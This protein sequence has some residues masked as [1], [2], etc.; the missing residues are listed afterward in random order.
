M[1]NIHAP[2]EPRRRAG[3][4]ARASLIRGA[5]CALLALA[6]P[7]WAA[8]QVDAANG[9]VTDDVTGLVW[10]RATF[11]G[12]ACANG[13]NPS[14]QTYAWQ[15]ALQTAV[16][17]N[18]CSHKGHSDWR[19]PNIQ[20][21]ASLVQRD[22]SNPAIDVDAFADA[23]VGRYWS[24]TSQSPTHAWNVGFFDGTVDTAPTSD[25]SAYR[26]RVRLVRGGQPFAGADL[27]GLPPG[28]PANVQAVAGPGQVVLS[29]GPPADGG[30]VT[31]YEVTMD[32]QAL[33][34]CS[35][36]PC[37]IT[38]LQ[39]G[40]PHEFIVTAVNDMGRAS[41]EPVRATPMAQPA[42]TVAPVPSLGAWA[43]ALLAGLMVPLA[44]W[45][46]GLA[47]KRQAR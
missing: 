18:A 9:T 44:R 47:R 28:T 37:T 4:A 23:P 30:S 3:A 2:S 27:L 10:D 41:A 35:A 43:L 16:T 20:E 17:A 12:T 42:P 38:G 31:G 46:S 14:T 26:Y 22:R 6:A 19:L 34:A 39:N 7:A 15:P 32:G 8:W 21:L 1:M 40:T 29:W 13:E 36:S 5:A 45:R 33:P 11:A 25:V 24:S